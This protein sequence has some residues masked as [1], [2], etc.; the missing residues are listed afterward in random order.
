ML[1]IWIA[2]ASGEAGG[3]NAADATQPVTIIVQSVLDGRVIG[4]K[5]YQY[6][7]SRGRAMG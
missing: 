5:A 2:I 7:L 4:E 1:I 6:A 3:A